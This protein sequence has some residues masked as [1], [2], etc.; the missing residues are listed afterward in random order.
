MLRASCPPPLRGR[1]AFAPRRSRLLPTCRTS[2]WERR[3]KTTF[4]FFRSRAFAQPRLPWIPCWWREVDSNHRRRKPA[5]LQSAPVG[6]L[7]IPPTKNAYCRGHPE[8]CQQFL[9]M[10]LLPSVPEVVRFNP[11]C[12]ARGAPDIW[13]TVRSGGLYSLKPRPSLQ[14]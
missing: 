7:G 9:G 11:D 10:N 6:R 14:R 12:G 4:H 3:L 8:D 5:D 1:V 2:H 13:R